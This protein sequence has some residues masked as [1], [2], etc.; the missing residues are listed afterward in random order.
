M[1]LHQFQ[2]LRLAQAFSDYLTSLKI[3]NSILAWSRFSSILNLC[4][5]PIL[6]LFVVLLPDGV[7]MNFGAKV[8][9]KRVLLEDILETVW[10]PWGQPRKVSF[11]TILIQLSHVPPP[12]G[13]FEI[14]LF[15]CCCWCLLGERSRMRHVYGF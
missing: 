4:W 6:Y 9:S 10:R 5:S 2:N 3:K 13:R 14:S 8:A 11:L 15:G 12:H 1:L 7:C